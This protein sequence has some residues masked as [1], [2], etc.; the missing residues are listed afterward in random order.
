VKKL[1]E[2]GKDRKARSSSQLMVKNDV[3]TS[4]VAEG[5]NLTSEMQYLEGADWEF[6]K[7]LAS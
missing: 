1:F 3:F 2:S 5:G 7:K 6:E 4:I